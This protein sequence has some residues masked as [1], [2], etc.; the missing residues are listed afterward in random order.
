MF[1]YYA[2]IKK[3]QLSL[4][5]HIPCKAYFDLQKTLQTANLNLIKYYLS[6]HRLNIFQINEQPI[7]GRGK[8]DDPM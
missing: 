8:D 2:L 6:N 1:T 7:T 5:R 3:N 4:L